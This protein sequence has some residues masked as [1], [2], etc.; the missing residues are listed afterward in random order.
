MKQGV[1]SAHSS[2]TISLNN[3][4]L[5]SVFFA[6]SKEGAKDV[7]IYASIYQGA[8][9][10][11]P[12]ALITREKLMKDSKE[13]IK[14][15]G[16][17]TLVKTDNKIH[18]FVVGVSFG[19]WANS[20][21][22]HYISSIDT[23][24]FKFQKVLHLSPFAN[25]SNLVR[26]NAIY[27]NL[28]KEFGFLLPI[29]HELANKYPLALVFNNL[30]ELLKIKKLTNAK[31][32]FQPSVVAI[33]D[34]LALF[35][36]RS[37]KS[38]NYDFYTM[39]CDNLLNC[40]DLTKTNLKN[41]DNSINLFKVNNDIFLLFNSDKDGSRNTLSLAIMKDYNDFHRILDIDKG[42]EMSY[43]SLFISDNK[44]HI[45]YTHNRDFIQY[46]QFLFNKKD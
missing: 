21:I 2:S 31:D 17:P 39:T 43:A 33:N 37:S 6:G 1:L 29:Y 44:A 14:K 20:K 8:N 12:F 34:K 36:F 24:D 30:G 15:I 27:V 10:L 22:Y 35:A 32:L 3:D 18:L 9:Y 38:A 45:T 26:A 5:L 28:G 41:Y 23:I 46:K 13:Y 19:G 4:Y 7:A 11:E 16:N 42:K 25:I 40:N